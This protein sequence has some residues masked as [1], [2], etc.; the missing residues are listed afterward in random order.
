MFLRKM[1]VLGLA[2]IVVGA[3]M[4][5][6]CAGGE[7]DVKSLRLDVQAV[8]ATQ[9]IVHREDAPDDVRTRIRLRVAVQNDSDREE[10]LPLDARIRVI[11][12]KDTTGDC[13][14]PSWIA[15]KATIGLRMGV[16]R[17]LADGGHIP[18]QDTW[19]AYWEKHSPLMMRLSFPE[20]P[21]TVVIPS[22]G[23]LSFELVC[24]GPAERQRKHDLAERK[25]YE[26]RATPWARHSR[27][28]I[29]IAE[30]PA[31][32]YIDIPTARKADI[33]VSLEVPRVD[34]E[35]NARTYSAL[36]AGNV[37]AEVDATEQ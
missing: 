25:E 32:C 28:W 8:S 24:K 17:A 35:N 14:L 34:A 30:A 36:A 1:G 9:S 19:A 15:R 22:K 37:V 21:K 29:E 2:A 13:E 16:L 26:E 27:E 3:F 7:K 20:T 6:V 33:I 5:A 11:V 31:D 18:K 4:L 10:A 12:N 23:K